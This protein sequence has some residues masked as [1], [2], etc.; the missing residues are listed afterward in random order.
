MPEIFQN[1]AQYD[2]HPQVEPRNTIIDNRN[3]EQK[4]QALNKLAAFKK[5]AEVLSKI[6][7]RLGKGDQSMKDYLIHEL[8][9]SG[10]E[11]G[12]FLAQEVKGGKATGSQKSDIKARSQAFLEHKQQEAE[13][14]L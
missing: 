6:K 10:S 1:L 8:K 2:Q 5:S 12:E 9:K 13:L 4:E 14:K 7:S 11:V 3:E